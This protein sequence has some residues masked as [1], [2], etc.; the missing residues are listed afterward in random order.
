MMEGKKQFTVILTE[1]IIW[2]LK[3][4]KINELN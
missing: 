2:K 1:S 3:K 4:I